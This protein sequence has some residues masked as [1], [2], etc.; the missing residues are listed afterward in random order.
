MA[1]SW[2]GLLTRLFNPRLLQVNRDLQ[3]EIDRRETVERSLRDSEERFRLIVDSALDAVISMD[4]DGRIL[5]WNTQAERTFGWIRQEA[6]GNELASLIVPPQ[7]RDAHRHGLRHYAKT[8]EGPVFNRRLEL[9]ALR[10]DGQEFPVELSVTQ[11]Q[12]GGTTIFNAFVCD[13]TDRKEAERRL[14]RQALEARMLHEATR[15]AVESDSFEQ[16]LQGCVDLIC[17]LLDWRVGHVYLPN[18][19]GT[20]LVPMTVWHVRDEADAE[21]RTVTEQ[22]RLNPGEGLPGRIYLS[23]EPAW[24]EDVHNDANFPRARICQ[25]LDLRAGFGFPIKIQGQ[26]VAV[27][28]FFSGV[29]LVPDGDLLATVRT[30]GEQIGRVVERKRA[31]EALRTSEERLRLALDAGHMGTWDWN[32]LTNSVTWSPGLERIHG[33]QP[34]T[35]PGTFEA[36]QNDIHPDDRDRVLHAITETVRTG[37]EHHLEYRLVWSDGSLHWV[38]ARGK[39]FHDEQGRP[40]R[41]IGICMDIDQRKQSEERLRDET[42]VTETLYRVSRSLSA[43]LDLN[44]LVQLVT[45]EATRLTGAEFGAFFHNQVNEQGESYT[46]Y[47]LSGVPRE[48]FSTFPMPRNT[49]VFAPTFRGEGILRL[50]DVTRDPRFGRN[51][52]YFGMPEGHL[53]VHSYLAVPVASRSGDVLG[54]LFLGHSRVGVFQERHERI[55]A[56]MASH[57]AV[58]IDNARLFQTVQESEARVRRFN[59]TLEQRVRE[60]TTQLE[61]A[62]HE[63]EAFSYS[64]SHDLRAPLRHI[65]GYADLLVKRATDVLDEK[66]RQYLDTISAAVQR[67]GQLIDDLL[68]FSRMSRRDLERAPIRT[69]ELVAEV[70]RQLEHETQGRVIEWMVGSLPDTVG[71][72]AMLRS[73]WYNLL[74]NAVKYTGRQETARIDIG[75]RREDGEVVFFVRDNGI[76]FDMKYADNLFG[77]FQRLHSSEQFE[78]TGIGLANVRRI[79]ARHGGQTW[80]ESAPN[81]GATFYFSLP[82]P[83]EGGRER[84]EVKK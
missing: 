68:A 66:S 1:N 30:V 61:Q 69:E 32:L 77:V 5:E 34:G 52:P 31:G 46:L 60:R 62:N 11:V 13:I 18:S 79:I 55:V 83:A 27:L 33:L 26:T 57:A 35:F 54:G 84:I 56:G 36:Y 15:L 40:V 53:P 51:E 14:A 37:R 45:D 38:E 76:G 2:D 24:I 82:L 44:R 63:L 7:S 73:V 72:R 48:K 81:H 71:D 22:T 10:R 29:E 64:V 3:R 70:R 78:G 42:Q 19:Q 49:E 80:A 74:S 20:E 6:I 59:E 17:R 67:M 23:G 25:H 28:E 12:F 8:G 41:M 4:S 43:E 58:A 21:F 50:D 65:A 16:A 75:C 39:V 47:T 9:T